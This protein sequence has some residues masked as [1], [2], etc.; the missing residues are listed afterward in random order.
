M[1]TTWRRLTRSQRGG[2]RHDHGMARSAWAQWILMGLFDFLLLIFVFWVWMGWILD[3]FGLVFWILM[4]FGLVG[5]LD[6]RGGQWVVWLFL[7]WVCLVFGGF[8]FGFFFLFSFFFFFLGFWFWWVVVAWW[9]WWW[10]SGAWVV[11]LLRERQRGRDR[12]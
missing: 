9:T 4:G 3:S 7:L 5:W 10:H 6:W 11:W 8:C 12:N 1:V 2:D